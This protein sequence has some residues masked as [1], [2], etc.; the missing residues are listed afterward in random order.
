MRRTTAAGRHEVRNFPLANTP[1][2]PPGR[3]WKS[4]L[5][6]VQGVCCV[7]DLDVVGDAAGTGE[8][9]DHRFRRGPLRAGAYRSGEEY[10]AVLCVASTP[11]GVVWPSV[12]ASFAM[13]VRAGSSR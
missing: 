4:P 9:S 10:V 5:S 8:V 1:G 11:A 13:A 3:Y 7:R 12:S 6:R 2:R